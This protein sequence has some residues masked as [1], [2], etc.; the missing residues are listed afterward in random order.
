MLNLYRKFE[1]LRGD[2]SPDPRSPEGILKIPDGTSSCPR[3]FSKSPNGRWGSGQ[4]TRS[5][6]RILYIFFLLSHIKTIRLLYFVPLA[7]PTTSKY[8][9]TCSERKHYWR[10]KTFFTIIYNYIIIYLVLMPTRF[11][12]FMWSI[13]NL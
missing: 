10:V 6:T 9:A 4:N 13:Y 8:I 5:K 2:F 11:F 12:I 1:F 3:G 7:K